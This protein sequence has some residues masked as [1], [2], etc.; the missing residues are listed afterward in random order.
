MKEKSIFSLHF[1][2]LF[3]PLP[4]LCS[5]ANNIIAPNGASRAA[6]I[7]GKN[8]EAHALSCYVKSGKFQKE[9]TRR[10]SDCSHVIAWD[11]CITISVDSGLPEPHIR[12]VEIAMILRLFCVF[13]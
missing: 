9:S 11:N 5:F 2:H 4:R 13:I 12:D 6:D 3:V 1:T 7:V 10:H 8:R